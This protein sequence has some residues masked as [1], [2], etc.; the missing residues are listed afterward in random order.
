[1][2]VSGGEVLILFLCSVF[3]VGGIQMVFVEVGGWVAVA[4][5]STYG[6][7]RLALFALA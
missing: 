7:T 1:M 5:H 2:T 6:G 4:T 3:A